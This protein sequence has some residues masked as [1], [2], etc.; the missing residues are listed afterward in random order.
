VERQKQRLID[1]DDAVYMAGFL[2]A[3]AKFYLQ[4]LSK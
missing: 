3:L 4:W 2:S 1:M